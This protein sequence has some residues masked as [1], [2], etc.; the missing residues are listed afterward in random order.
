MLTVLY[1]AFFLTV[2]EV[3]GQAAQVTDG[4]PAAKVKATT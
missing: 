4:L 1:F 2:Y 3:V